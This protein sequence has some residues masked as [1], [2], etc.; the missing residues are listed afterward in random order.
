MATHDLTAEEIEQL[1]ELAAAHFWPHARG[2]GDMSSETGV[3]LVSRAQGVW[4]EDVEGKQWFDVQAGMWLKNVGHGRKEI[5]DAVYAQMQDISYAPGGTVSLSTVKLAAKIARL[6][7]DKEARVFF[8]SGGSEAIET[9][10]K[11]AKKFHRNNGEAARYK[12]ISRRGSYHGGTHAC[13]SLGGGGIAGATDYEPLMPGNIHVA[14]PNEYRCAFCRERGSCNLECA[15]DVEQAI[16]QAGPSTVAA[17]VGEPISASS[18]IHVPHPEYWDTVADICK[19][20]GVLLILD[21]VITAFGRTGAWFGSEHWNIEPDIF[22]VAKGLTSGYLPM[23]AAVASKRVADAFIGDEGAAFRH[24]FTFGG[25]PASCAAA[26]ANL[27]ILETEGL[28]KNSAQLG[29]Y[30]FERLQGLYE[31]PIVGNV[32]GGKGLLASLELVA[33]R[34]TR[35]RFPE[36]AKLAKK[37]QPLLNRHGLLG[38]AGDVILMAPPLCATKDEIDHLVEQLD[39]IL[40]E[41]TE[42]L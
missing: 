1:R 8:V 15:R 33:D 3:K 26:L 37:L 34:T 31:H 10:L 35:Q 6:A 20:H 14:A 9:A 28:V 19:R 29:D 27:E 18:G 25:N 21:E 12:V 24:I 23:G 30:L 39:Q 2:A 11:M 13:L 40:G 36:T 17:F 22:A 7:P 41:L 32:T 38:R 4:V 16:Q 5:A 42:S